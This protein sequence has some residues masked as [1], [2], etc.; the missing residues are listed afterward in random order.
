MNNSAILTL[1]SEI[2]PS[3]LAYAANQVVGGLQALGPVLGYAG[4]FI[5]SLSLLDS[6][7]IGAALTVH[8]FDTA[9]TAIPDRTA[10]TPSYADLSRRIASV[11]IGTGDYA[12]INNLKIA[13]IPDINLVLPSNRCWVY[14]VSNAAPTW[15]AA[16]KLFSRLFILS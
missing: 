5:K 11:S 3:N 9:P 1:E 15:P 7:N 13:Y 16:S 10:F 4:L 14:F 8:F 12:T 2:T 6:G